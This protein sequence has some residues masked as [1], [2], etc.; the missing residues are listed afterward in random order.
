MDVA[1]ATA[2]FQVF[3]G[4]Q[5]QGF[6]IEG[7][8]EMMKVGTNDRITWTVRDAPLRSEAIDYID[9]RPEAYTRSIFQ[10]NE[11]HIL[12]MPEGITFGTKTLDPLPKGMWTTYPIA[13]SGFMTLDPN[14][15]SVYDLA[16]KRVAGGSPAHPWPAIADIILRA[17]GIRDQVQLV[18]GAKGNDVQLADREVDASIYGVLAADTPLA[19]SSPLIHKTAQLN[20]TL[21]WIGF[22][23]ELFDIMQKQNPIWAAANLLQPMPSLKGMMRGA[24]KVDYDV[25]FEDSYC[26]GGI[27]VVMMTSPNTEEG[28]VYLMQ[29]AIIENADVSDE[30]FPFIAAWKTRFGHAFIPQ[31]EYHDGARRAYEEFG[32]T[33]GIERIAEWRAQ[34]GG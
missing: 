15:K 4:L 3:V 6:F 2:D 24:T 18:V 16:G 34:Q 14:I 23:L 21:R 5:G 32:V 28:L 8:R 12:L 9:Q 1:T 26:V 30:Y 17:A 33:Y 19:A 25:M 20:S 13:C 27:T 31:S 29:R 7:M 22:D 11:E 10:L